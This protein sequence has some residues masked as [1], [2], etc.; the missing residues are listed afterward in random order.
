MTNRIKLEKLNATIKKLNDSINESS[1]EMNKLQNESGE[2]LVQ[3][4][5]DENLLKNSIWEI[6][7]YNEHI[8][9]KYI[10][11]RDD[12]ILGAI[13]AMCSESY[14]SWL[15]LEPGIQLR[16]DEDAASLH[17]NEAKT[18]LPFSSKHQMKITGNNIADKLQK[19][20]RESTTLEQLIHQFAIK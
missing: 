7:Y 9:L 2:L 13:S 12:A 20:K 5:T 16:I 10:G 19:L 4:I 11:N 3:V 18:V 8:Y 1:E 15:D 17:F 14:H 6:D